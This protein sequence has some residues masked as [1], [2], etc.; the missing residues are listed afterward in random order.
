MNS[1]RRLG[2]FVLLF[3]LAVASI[4]RAA[5]SAPNAPKDPIN[6]A[7]GFSGAGA[8]IWDERSRTF[9]PNTALAAVIDDDV[10][11]GWVPP[12]GKTTL[13]VQLSQDADLSTVTIYAPGAAGRYSL[14]VAENAEALANGQTSAVGRNLDLSLVNNTRLD[15][16]SAKYLLIELDVTKTA[17]LRGVQ[18]IG[19]PHAAPTSTTSVVAPKAGADDSETKQQGE[20][21]EVNFALKAIGGSTP[22]NPDAANAL[23]DGDTATAS[24]LAPRTKDTLIRLASAVEIDRVALAVGKAVGEVAIFAND[25]EGHDIRDI[26]V[27]KLDGKTE[28][29][30]LDTPGIRA[31]FV[32]LEWTPKEGNADLVV[33][34]VG[35]FAQARVSRAEPPPGSNAVV[36]QIMP[37]F[38]VGTP[39]LPSPTSVARSLPTTTPAPPV[40]LPQPRPVSL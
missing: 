18:V 23:I 29:V 26:G 37:M 8:F 20:V 3:G 33:K 6:L 25:G 30:S 39:S 40:Q 36:V 1:H 27:V 4:L 34:E 5:E 38:N 15:G 19:M 24:N 28:T 14:S 17:P 35:V 32:R 2:L 11:S 22:V 12:T 21:A 13:L 9:V 31:E 16:A 7:R 10:A